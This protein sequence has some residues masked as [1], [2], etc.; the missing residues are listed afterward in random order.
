MQRAKL[1]SAISLSTRDKET[2]FVQRNAIGRIESET[3]SK[4]IVQTEAK[5]EQNWATYE[6]QLQKYLTQTKKQFPNWLECHRADGSSYWMNTKTNQESHEHPGVR[7][8]QVNKRLLKQKAEQE[9]LSSFTGVFARKHAIMEAIVGLK[10][11]VVRDLLKARLSLH[12][13]PAQGPIA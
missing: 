6:G 4:Y 11:K 13:K 9:L 12:Y 8:F 7:I 2:Y 5:F 10:H 3:I 1:R